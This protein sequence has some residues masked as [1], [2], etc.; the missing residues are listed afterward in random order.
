MPRNSLVQNGQTQCFSI[1]INRLIKQDI[2]RSIIRFTKVLWYFRLFDRI[3][4]IVIKDIPST[5]GFDYS[6]I[7]TMVRT[8]ESRISTRMITR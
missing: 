5:L 3:D 2:S 4:D 8:T 1:E 7:M 6:D